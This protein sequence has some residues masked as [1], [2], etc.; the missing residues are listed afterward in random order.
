[1]LYLTGLRALT[2]ATC[3][4]CSFT[5]LTLLLSF[6]SPFERKQGATFCLGIIPPVAVA[7]QVVWYVVGSQHC[8]RSI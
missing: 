6:A 8:P 2:T 3:T 5:T 7:L 4:I 1:M